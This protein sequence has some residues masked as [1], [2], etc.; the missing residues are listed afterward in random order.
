MSTGSLG[1][2]GSLATAQLQQMR[3]A[4]AEHTSQDVSSHARAQQA[5]QHAESAA[6]IGEMEQEGATAERDADGRRLW[7]KPSS[8]KQLIGEEPEPETV[9]SRDPSGASGTQLDLSG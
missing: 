3:S 9:R 4:D 6:G 8:R 2:I 7:E 5:D 1:S